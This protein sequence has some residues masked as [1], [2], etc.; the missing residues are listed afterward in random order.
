MPWLF[1]ANW[2][3]GLVILVSVWLTMPYFF[4]VSMGALQS[5]PDELTRRRGSTAAAGGRSSGG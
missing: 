5:I 4:L 2:A 3:Q 1:D